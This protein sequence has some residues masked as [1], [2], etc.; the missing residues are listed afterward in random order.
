[1]ITSV[2]NP[3]YQINGYAKLAVQNGYSGVYGYLQ[4]Y[5]DQAYQIDANGNVTTNTTGVLHLT[6]VS[7]PRTP[8]RR[9]W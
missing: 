8:A 1:M 5:F 7:S 4:Q 9:H 2:G 3:Y 6:A